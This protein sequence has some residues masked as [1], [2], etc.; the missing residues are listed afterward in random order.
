ML[1]L[2]L[3]CLKCI[4][5]SKYPQNLSNFGESLSKIGFLSPGIQN[6]SSG[7][8]SGRKIGGIPVLSSVLF[9][10]GG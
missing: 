2:M 8:E 10:A 6:S 7:I 9:L 3:I 1:T 4:N 5:F